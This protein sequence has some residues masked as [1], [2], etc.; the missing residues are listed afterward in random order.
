MDQVI[1][2]PNSSEITPSSVVRAGRWWFQRRGV[3]PVPLILLCLVLPSNFLLSGV[4]LSSVLIGIVLCEAVRIWAV[5]YAGSA[6]RTRGD[7][8]PGLVHAGPFRYVR[9]PL[10][11]A[12][13]L[14]Y[15]LC[16]IAF[17]FSWLSVF[18]AAYF[19]VQYTFIVAFEE[20]LLRREFD[21]AYSFYSAR[22][23]R[24]VP[25]FTP[26]VE[27]SGHRFD[28]RKALRSERATLLALAV[29]VGL[30]FAKRA[31]L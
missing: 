25:S 21:V 18:I 14:L 12:N 20:D 24:W 6:T 7:Q 30:V 16:G 9:N 31:Y 23:A 29:I 28:L 4:Q 10:Y 8:V 17:G 19:A 5:G 27:P 11:I 13:G 2:R 15:T 1:S 3:S 26:S 22:V